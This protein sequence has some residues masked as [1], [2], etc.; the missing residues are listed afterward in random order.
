M[1]HTAYLRH[2]IEYQGTAEGGD[3]VTRGGRGHTTPAELQLL[4]ERLVPRG[5]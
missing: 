1:D 3:R 2:A 4:V 5:G